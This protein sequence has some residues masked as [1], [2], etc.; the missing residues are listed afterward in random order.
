MYEPKYLNSCTLFT[1][2]L[3][4]EF[5]SDSVGEG[6]IYTVLLLL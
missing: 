4:K 1:D 6:V 3:S 5:S 2:E